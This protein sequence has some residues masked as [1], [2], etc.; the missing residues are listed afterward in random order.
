[1]GLQRAPLSL[2]STIQELLA[3]KSSGSSVEIEIMAVGDLPRWL[4]DTPLSAKVGTN[5]V[6]KR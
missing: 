6:D 3:R 1:V 2:M 4:R 5:F